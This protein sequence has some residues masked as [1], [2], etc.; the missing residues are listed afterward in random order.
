MEIASADPGGSA[1]RSVNM[2]LRF[3][4]SILNLR[5]NGDGDI[6]GL[7]RRMADHSGPG[8]CFLDRYGGG[9]G[10][11]SDPADTLPCPTHANYSKLGRRTSVYEVAIAEP[12]EDEYTLFAEASWFDGSSPGVD[13]GPTQL[14]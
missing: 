14:T 12:G 7:F 10:D 13:D 4:D 9:D 1:D 3:G 11:F 8:D 5:V 6:Q 2:L